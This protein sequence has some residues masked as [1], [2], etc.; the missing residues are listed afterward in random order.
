MRFN[1]CFTFFICI[2][3]FSYGKNH[4]VLSSYITPEK[5][6]VLKNDPLWD[7]I[8]ALWEALNEERLVRGDEDIKLHDQV[9]ELE[10]REC[11]FDSNCPSIAPFCHQNRCV[12]CDPPCASPTPYCLDHTS[13]VECLSTSDCPPSSPLCFIPNNECRVCWDSYGIHGCAG[14]YEYCIV[15]EDRCEPFTGY[16]YNYMHYCVGPETQEYTHHD[17]LYDAV[18]AC[19]GYSSCGCITFSPG[20]NLGEYTLHEGGGIMYTEYGSSCYV[21]T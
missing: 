10:A 14:P 7:N 2:I 21:K 19:D 16:A 11:V 3:S 5:I 4:G 8:T 13:C 6:K 9:E 20:Y 15:E 17:T 18:S 12:D 1:I